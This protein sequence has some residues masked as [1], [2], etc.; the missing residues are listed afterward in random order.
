L[1]NYKYIFSTYSTL[2]SECL[3]K[4]MRAGFVMFKSK[5]N[6][7]FSSMFGAYENL[8]NKGPFWCS[9]NKLDKKEIERVF[10]FVTKTNKSKWLKKTN[11]YIKKKIGFD[12]Q[13]KTFRNIIK[14]YI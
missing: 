8:E 11:A 6:P 1:L 7:E 2:A 4:G 12:Y 5:Q 14:G 9:S 13:N 3:A 10:K